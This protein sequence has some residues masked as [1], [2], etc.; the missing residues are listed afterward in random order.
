MQSVF[1]FPLALAI[2]DLAD[3]KELPLDKEIHLSDRDLTTRTYSP[4]REAYP[5]RSGGVTIAELLR[6][7]VSLSDNMAC[8]V[9]F[10]ELGGPKKLEQYLHRLGFQGVSV[11]ATEEEMATGWTVQ[12]TNWC[13]PITMN[14]LLVRFFQGKILRPAST[15][16]LRKWMLETPTGPARLKGL[17][18]AGTPVMHKTGTSSTN[19]KGLSAATNDAGVITLPDGRHVA[20]TVF[21]SDSTAGQ[22]EREQTIAQ[23]ARAAYLHYTTK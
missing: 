13:E 23:A 1:K 10:R 21:V 15:A 5:K 9:L 4:L 20:V 3:R 19:E 11:K 6:Y 8:D 18:P 14:D 17:L 7:S 2:L 12:Y 16:M 22:K